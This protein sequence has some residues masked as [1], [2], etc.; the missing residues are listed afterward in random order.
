MKLKLQLGEY[1]SIEE[2]K[3]ANADAGYYFFSPDTMR[4]F[5]S[6]VGEN[7]Y[8][9][10]DGWYFVTSEKFD[11]KTPRYYTVRKMLPGGDVVSASEFQQYR[12]APGAKAAAERWAKQSIAAAEAQIKKEDQN[13]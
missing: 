3:R 10:A 7:V 5:D 4:F 12:S 2:L 9:G 8:R 13:E 11:Y 6:R 1:Y